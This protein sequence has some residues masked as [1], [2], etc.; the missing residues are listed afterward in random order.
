VSEEIWSTAKVRQVESGAYPWNALK[1]KIG[2]PLHVRW[3][4]RAVFMHCGNKTLGN[5]I[6]I[7]KNRSD[8]HGTL[9][10]FS[11]QSLGKTLLCG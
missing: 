6:I 8:S 3:S 9:L 2:K 4:I 11:V 10:P 7:R 1:R 5:K